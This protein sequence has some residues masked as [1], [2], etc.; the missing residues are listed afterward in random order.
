[1]RK[2]TLAAIKAALMALKRSYLGV[3]RAILP[4]GAIRNLSLPNRTNT[5]YALTFRIREWLIIVFIAIV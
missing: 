3:D 2:C 5:A 4:F 1:M